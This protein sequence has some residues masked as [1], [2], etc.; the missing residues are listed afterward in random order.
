MVEALA[1]QVQ[2][3]RVVWA[4]VLAVELGLLAVRL[5]ETGQQ[6]QLLLLAAVAGSKQHTRLLVWG[7]IFL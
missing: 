7:E 1:A 2:A 5:L 4:G 3:P 6:P